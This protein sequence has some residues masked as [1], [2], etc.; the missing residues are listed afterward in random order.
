MGLLAAITTVTLHSS[1]VVEP[2]KEDWSLWEQYQLV[3]VPG[4]EFKVQKTW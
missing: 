3:G 1:L 2:I 4:A